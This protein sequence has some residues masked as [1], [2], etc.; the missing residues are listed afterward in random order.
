MKKIFHID[1]GGSDNSLQV[2]SIRIGAKH[3]SFAIT[4]KDGDQLH[5]LAYCTTGL[6]DRKQLAEFL[7]PVLQ[8][9][10]LQVL[11]SYDFPHSVLISSKEYQGE[12]AGLL[13]RVMGNK[14]DNSGIV[15]DLIA[16]WQ[17][18]NMYS[19]PEEIREWMHKKIPAASCRHQYSLGIKSITTAD[20]MGCLAVDFRTDELTVIVSKG[21]KLLLAQTFGFTSP[22]DVLYYLLKTCQLFSLSQA[23]VQLR[24]SGLIDKQ[25]ALYTGLCQYFINLHFREANWELSNEYPPHFFT[26][27]N[28]LAKCAS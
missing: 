27:L 10:F 2:L 13:L 6:W 22:G 3:G 20:I 4:G 19:L 17:L 21:N 9:S 7:D 25:S 15:A 26:S 11:V 1:N 23:E 5:E 14:F 12:N 24:L 28:D 16:E 8:S 18:Y